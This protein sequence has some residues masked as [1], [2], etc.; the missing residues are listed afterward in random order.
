M[1]VSYFN[2]LYFLLS[3]L[4][5]FQFQKCFDDFNN[6]F[7]MHFSFQ[8]PHFVTLDVEIIVGEVFDD[9]NIPI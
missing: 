5:I 3:C 7:C 9:I 4:S 2:L 6:I 8:T 1:I